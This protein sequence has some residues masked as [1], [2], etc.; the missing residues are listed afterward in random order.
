MNDAERPQRKRR[1]ISMSE[2]EQD[3]FLDSARVVRLASLRG[4]GHPDVTPLWFV[5]VDRFLWISSLVPSQR[6][7]N[8]VRDPRVAGVIDDGDGYRE[9]RG[10][11]VIGYAEAVGEQP[12][13]GLPHSELAR[14]EAAYAA[15]YDVPDGQMYDGR[16]AWL[17]VAPASVLSWD[18]RKI[19]DAS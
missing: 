5:W 8:I 6:W 9:L 3:A 4:D 11:E 18:H 2:D 10:V 12:R 15:K 19:S 13:T 7:V 17:R 14:V 1:R 16:H